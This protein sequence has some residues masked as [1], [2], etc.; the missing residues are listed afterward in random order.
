M[1]A[2]PVSLYLDL[3]EGQVADMEVVAAAAIAFSRAIKELAYILD[4]TAQIRVELESG[5]EGS[6]SLNS[7]VRVIRGLK[8]NPGFVAGIA[9]GAAMWFLGNV[10]DYAFDQVAD[11]VRK[12]LSPEQAQ[13]LS[14][15]E[16]NKIAERV[17]KALN[18]GAAKPQVEGIFM[19]LERDPAIKGVG[20]SP[21]PGKRPEV[22]VPRSA[23][24]D[25][26]GV[27]LTR[28]AAWSAA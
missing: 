21:T 23:F 8:N 18:A 24:P 22:I 1:T 28:D 15:E 19:E 10:G 16:I 20:V 6:L 12:H 11:L 25:R 2:T 27:S 4:P 13:Q 5:T 9:G 3:E 14:E 7:L 26:A 17:V